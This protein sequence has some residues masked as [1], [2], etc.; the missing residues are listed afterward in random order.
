MYSPSILIFGLTA[1]QAVF[2]IP[3]PKLP[4]SSG[5]ITAYSNN[6]HIESHLSKRSLESNEVIE[7][8]LGFMPRGGSRIVTCVSIHLKLEKQD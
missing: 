6:A 7:C 8:P 2:G 5:N 4:T 1:L 3:I